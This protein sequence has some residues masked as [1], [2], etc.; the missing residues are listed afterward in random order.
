MTWK[1]C[2]DCDDCQ[3]MLVEYQSISDRLTQIEAHLA[4]LKP[5]IALANQ[6]LE[7]PSGKLQRALLGR[8]HGT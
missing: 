7:S 3:P 1:T 8:K 4:K 2:K 6:F 5:L